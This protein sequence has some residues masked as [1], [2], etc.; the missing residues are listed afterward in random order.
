MYPMSQF[1]KLDGPVHSMIA[2]RSPTSLWLPVGRFLSTTTAITGGV[3]VPWGNA[4][5]LAVSE[6]GGETPR[7][8]FEETMRRELCSKDAMEISAS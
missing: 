8:A 4:I 7:K 3:V 6:D 1:W 5:G 2:A